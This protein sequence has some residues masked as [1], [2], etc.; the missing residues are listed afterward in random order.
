MIRSIS[1]DAVLA[2]WESTRCSRAVVE[3]AFD[4]V[5]CLTYIP[6]LD[7]YDCA[8][9]A[10]KAAVRECELHIPGSTIKYEALGGGKCALEVVR[11]VKGEE[12]NQWPHLFSLALTRSD[13]RPDRLEIIS[14]SEDAG[15][16]HDNMDEAED[17]INDCYHEATATISAKDLTESLVKLI[18]TE[19]R[20]VGMKSSG[21]TYFMAESRADPYLSIAD[22]LN[23]HGPELV[24][25]KI[26][27]ADNPTMVKQALS[28]VNNQIKAGLD[29]MLDKAADL[30]SRGGRTR[31][32]GNQSRVDEISHYIGLVKTYRKLLGHPM[33]EAIKAIRQAQA[34]LGLEAIRNGL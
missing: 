28:S 20:A 30:K 26:T 7:R 2:L 6:P 13:K 24:I 27:L 14:C 25:C 15:P 31:S 23:K 8:R 32:N 34:E 3:K 29:R 9:E 11:K 10:A 22:E 4:D 12:R 5:G 16:I 18:R 17:I 19:C 33:K 1:S 21:G